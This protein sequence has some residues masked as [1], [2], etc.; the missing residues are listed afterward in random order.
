MCKGHYPTDIETT[1]TIGQLARIS[2][3]KASTIR[4]YERIGLLH[5]EGRTASNYRHYGEEALQRLRFIRASQATG[6]TLEDITVLLGLRDGTRRTCEDVQV[7]IEERLADLERRVADLWHVQRVLKA[8]LEKCR[9][10]Q[11]SGCCQI[12][13]TLTA[14]SATHP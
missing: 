9:A 6:F 10:T 1:Y 12:I 13:D 11:G 8:T 5:P 4:Y 3:V 2:G 7:L 14:T